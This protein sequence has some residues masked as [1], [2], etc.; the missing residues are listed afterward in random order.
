MLLE[1]NVGYVMYVVLVDE[2][3]LGNGFNIF[4]WY[5]VLVFKDDSGMFDG[6][7]VV[8]DWCDV[9]LEMEV[10]WCEKM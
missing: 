8:V 1:N 10:E 7:L 4:C 5:N 9:L 3:Y 2:V 6:V